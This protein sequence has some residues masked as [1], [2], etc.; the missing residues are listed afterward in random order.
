M[1]YAHFMGFG[2]GFM[3][4]IWVLLIG[5]VV[6]LLFAISRQDRSLESPS[7]K[8]ILDRRYARG[9]IDDETYERMKK[10]LD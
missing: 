2:G 10:E 3:W 6:W 9:E 8:E 1:D 5:V 4:I 7:P